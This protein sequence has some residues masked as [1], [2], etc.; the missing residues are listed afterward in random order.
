M[1]TYIGIK[2]EYL[3]EGS[4]LLNGLL[5]DEFLLLIKTKNAHWNV[6]GPDFLEKHEFFDGQ[7]KQ[8]ADISDDV[9]ERIRSLGHYA[10]ATMKEFLELTHLTEKTSQENDGRSFVKELLV[11]HESI[12]IHLHENINRYAEKLHDPGTSDFI[13]GIMEIHEKMAW[14]L[15]EHLK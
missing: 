12:I 5:A 1:D 9:A 4:H 10:P 6:E 7:Y 15:R 8:L 2:P 13:T 14:M 11:D 3:S